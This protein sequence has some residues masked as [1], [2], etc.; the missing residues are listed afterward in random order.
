MSRVRQLRA[1]VRKDVLLEA[2]TKETIVAMALFALVSMVIFQFAVGQRAGDSS[3]IAGGIIWATVSLAA[4]LGV[5]RTWV[6]EREQ[7]VLDGLLTAPVARLT[8]FMARAIVLTLFLLAVEVVIV[9]LGIVFFTRQIAPS[10]LALMA[11]VCVLANLCI[12][13]AGTLLASMS[14]FSR[15]RELVIPV[16]LLP[17]LVPVVIAASG[18]TQAVLGPGTQLAEYL[19]YCR[20]LAVYAAVFS[21]VAYATY[22]HVLDD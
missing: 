7:R 14:V 18:A 9:P 13:V 4:V 20:F 15:A 16:L 1:L 6:P 21:L 22:D 3:L 8:M 17:A 2:H 11:G 12:A 10:D 5:G 19:A